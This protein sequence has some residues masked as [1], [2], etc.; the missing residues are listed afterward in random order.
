MHIA[1]TSL[2]D[3]ALK[4]AEHLRSRQ[5]TR[6]HVNLRLGKRFYGTRGANTFLLEGFSQSPAAREDF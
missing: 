1:V 5:I 4:T 2:R 6:S 3:L